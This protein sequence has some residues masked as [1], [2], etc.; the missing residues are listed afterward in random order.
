M[1]KLFITWS[2]A[3]L[4]LASCNSEND[5]PEA[6]QNAAQFSASIRGRNAGRAY[7]TAWEAGDAIGISGV[8]G[9]KTYANV[10]YTTTSGDGT[11]TVAAT[12]SEIY[13]QDNA[14]VNFTAYYPFSSDA[15]AITADT[16]YQARQKSFDFLWAQGK[17]SKANPGV[18]F[19][20]EH[21]MA[22][23]V[24]TVRKGADV[25]FDEVKSAVLSLDG[26]RH[27]GKFDAVSG[28]AEATGNAAAMWE[29]A[30]NADDAD[31]NA[32]VN[33]DATAET[34]SYTLIL[35]PQTFDA[36]LPFEAALTGKQSFK[37]TLDF[38]A[39]NKNAGDA[40]AANAWVAGRQYNLSVTLHKTALTVDGCT[41]TAWDTTDGGNI[42]AE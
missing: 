2:M 31:F 28:V 11:F 22:K 14:E 30:N 27:Q 41:I 38:T 24:L 3:M 37:A 12:G 40:D 23:L 5:A 7:D 35:F 29:F 20:F 34:V 32:P 33:T 16:W 13:F 17:G 6:G 25:S 26:F 18:A 21:R 4:M 10:E 36:T 9:S 8:T 1:K 19:V 39:A 15:T 42:D